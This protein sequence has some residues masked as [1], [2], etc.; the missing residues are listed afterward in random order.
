MT[1]RPA[2]LFR[3]F[4]P[5]RRFLALATAA[6]L[7]TTTALAPATAFELFGKK[8]FEP[9]DEEV[10]VVPDAQPYTLDLTVRGG[11]ESLVEAVGNASALSRE[12][13]R[14]PAGTAGLLARARAITAASSRRSMRAAITAGPLRS[15]S[16]AGPPRRSVR[17]WCCR[18][19]FPWP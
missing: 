7:L 16:A 18:T 1:P 15:A 6:T 4:I 14:P 13:D 10:A 19:R 5:G 17:M 11:D 9:D 3:R 2:T 8:F 12:A